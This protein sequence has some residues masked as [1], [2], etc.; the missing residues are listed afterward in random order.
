MTTLIEQLNRVCKTS[1]VLEDN[2]SLVGD[3][4]HLADYIKHNPVKLSDKIKS[5]DGKPAMIS[6][7]PLHGIQNLADGSAIRGIELMETHNCSAGTMA[8]ILYALDGTGLV[9]IDIEGISKNLEDMETLL[10]QSS[11]IRTEYNKAIDSP[12]KIYLRAIGVSKSK[13]SKS[14]RTI[15]SIAF[16]LDSMAS[17]TPSEEDELD[18]AEEQ[19]VEEVEEPVEV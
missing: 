15:T 16:I 11:T 4:V 12:G 18:D 6:R 7:I 3:I 9:H 8:N 13:N 14:K 5:K 19:E 10:H 2:K 1:R 17:G